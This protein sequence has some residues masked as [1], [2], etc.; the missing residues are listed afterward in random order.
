MSEN[1]LSYDPVETLFFWMWISGCCTSIAPILYLG[2]FDFYE[3]F[4]VVGNEYVLLAVSVAIFLLS[5]SHSY[6]LKLLLIARYEDKWA[7]ME[8]DDSA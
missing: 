6:C 8:R 1:K 3:P 4:P 7:E 2:W 5:V